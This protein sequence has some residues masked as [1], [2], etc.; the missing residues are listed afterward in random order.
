MA[1]IGEKRTFQTGQF[2]ENG[3]LLSTTRGRSLMVERRFRRLLCLTLC[4]ERHYGN[5]S[6]DVSI[7]LS[8]VR[9]RRVVDRVGLV[10]V[11][12]IP[13]EISGSLVKKRSFDPPRKL[14][15]RVNSLLF[16]SL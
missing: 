16:A 5:R 4:G 2:N 8:A 11:E 6:I 3:R 1:G 9:T 12:L 7:G 10:L 13:Q 14:S 15:S